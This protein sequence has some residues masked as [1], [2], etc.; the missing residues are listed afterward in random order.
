MERH[1]FFCTSISIFFCKK[2]GTFRTNSGAITT[3]FDATFA[4]FKE[5]GAYVQFVEH[6]TSLGRRASYISD[7]VKYLKL[8]LC[9]SSIT[10]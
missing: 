1:H 8:E 3:P 4:S 10:S 5:V 2:T 6:L 9:Y 7:E